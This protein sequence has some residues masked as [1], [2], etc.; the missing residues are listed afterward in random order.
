MSRQGE[1]DSRGGDHRGEEQGFTDVVHDDDRFGFE[2]AVPRFWIINGR[3][4]AVYRRSHSGH[5]RR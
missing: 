4:E 2:W 3:R 1:R 5:S